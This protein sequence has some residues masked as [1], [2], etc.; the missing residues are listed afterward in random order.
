MWLSSH[1]SLLPI[2]KCQYCVHNTGT[3]YLEYP[4]T[5]QILPTTFSSTHTLLLF[6]IQ[7]EPS[8]PLLHYYIYGCLLCLELWHQETYSQDT[9]VS[10]AARLHTGWSRVQ[11]WLGGRTY[12][13]YETSKLAL[14]VYTTPYS[15]GI[16][17]TLPVE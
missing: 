13:F 11:T 1:T 4:T 15:M 14:G 8:K 7:R 9:S 5:A 6:L 17:D 12:F 10:I 3:G 16:R 2:L